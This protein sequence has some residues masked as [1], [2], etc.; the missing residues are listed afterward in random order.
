[1]IPQQITYSEIEHIW[2]DNLIQYQGKV[3]HTKENLQTFP[4]T[5]NL[6][7]EGVSKEEFYQ[8][9]DR[10]LNSLGGW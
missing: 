1:M 9:Y 3:Y 2:G 6:L 4:D 7:D 8:I 5:L 10:L